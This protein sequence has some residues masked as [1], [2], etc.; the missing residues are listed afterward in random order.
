MASFMYHGSSL[1]GGN[2]LF[3]YE[4]CDDYI[5]YHIHCFS[6]LIIIYFFVAFF[7][8]INIISNVSSRACSGFEQNCVFYDL[9]F[10]LCRRLISL[11]SLSCSPLFLIRR[12]GRCMIG[13]LSISV[14]LFFFGPMLLPF[15]RAIP[16]ASLSSWCSCMLQ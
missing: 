8:I 16:Y 9:V 3:I 4:I 2:S 6:I 12:E 13:R 7:A 15:Q 11:F 14:L 5:L 1:L 10:P